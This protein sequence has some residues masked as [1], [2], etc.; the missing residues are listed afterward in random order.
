MENNCNP[1]FRLATAL[2]ETAAGMGEPPFLLALDCRGAE[3]SARKEGSPMPAAV[4]GNA[5]AV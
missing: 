1:S 4:S 2:P 5:V 3:R